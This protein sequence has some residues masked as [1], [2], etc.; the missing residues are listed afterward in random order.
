MDQRVV[1][2]LS[3]C[4]FD[5]RFLTRNAMR[6]F[7]QPHQSFHHRRDGFDFAPYPSVDFEKGT[8]AS[9]GKP[10]ATCRIVVA[11]NAHGGLPFSFVPA[12]SHS[13]GRQKIRTLRAHAAP[14][15]TPSIYESI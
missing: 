1:Q 10:F 8:C 5:G 13:A 2:G 12:T 4:Q 15:T 6:S 3:E 14:G 7:D 11:C 9:E